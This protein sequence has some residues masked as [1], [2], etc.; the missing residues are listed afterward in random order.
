MKAAK[1]RVSDLESE[2]EARAKELKKR[3][4]EVEVLQKKLSSAHAERD[5]ATAG[6]FLIAHRL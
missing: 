5:T 1:E 4:E 3:E 6:T 2:G